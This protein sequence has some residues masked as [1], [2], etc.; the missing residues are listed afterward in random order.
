MPRASR[1]DR[2]VQ[3]QRQARAVDRGLPTS[4]FDSRRPSGFGSIGSSSS[5]VESTGL[6]AKDATSAQRKGWFSTWPTS[7][8]ILGLATL[9]LLGYGLWRTLTQQTGVPAR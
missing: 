3:R 1:K 2:K 8:K 7:V 6:L 9:A 4:E 5:V